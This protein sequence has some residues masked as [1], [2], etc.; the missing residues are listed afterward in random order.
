MKL[1]LLCILTFTQLTIIAKPSNIV[2]FLV[3][4]L[5]WKDL[6]C[7]GAKLYET[8]NIDQLCKAG[9]KFERAYTTA[10]I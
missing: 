6:K 3:D 7:Y 10:P 2:F 4:D 9:M 5:G 1:L 8:P